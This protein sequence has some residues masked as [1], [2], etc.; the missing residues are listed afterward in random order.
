MTFVQSIISHGDTIIV[1]I[2]AIILGFDKFKNGTSILRK[3]IAADYKERNGQLEMR[4]K[5]FQANL[6]ETNVKLAG[7]EAT[8][9]EKDERIKELREDLQGRNPDIINLLKEISLSN[10]EIKH[11]MQMM[12]NDSTKE[13]KHQTEMIEGQVEREMKIDK[14]SASNVGDPMLVPSTE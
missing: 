13:R 9:R 14:A 12:H 3:E 6:N 1:A 11:F 5:E 7:L 4:L 8:L 2:V 10:M